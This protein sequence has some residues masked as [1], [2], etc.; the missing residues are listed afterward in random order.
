MRRLGLAEADLF[1]ARVPKALRPSAAR[2]ARAAAG[3]AA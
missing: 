1:D 3:A 2:W